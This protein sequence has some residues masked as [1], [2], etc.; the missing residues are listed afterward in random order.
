MLLYIW[1]LIH[2]LF[3][4]P[5]RNEKTTENGNARRIKEAQERNAKRIQETREKTQQRTEERNSRVVRQSRPTLTTL[6]C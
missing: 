2:L 1:V 6:R 4:R 3:H 5:S